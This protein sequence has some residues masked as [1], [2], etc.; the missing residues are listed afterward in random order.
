MNALGH[1]R[2]QGVVAAIEYLI[3]LAALHPAKHVLAIDPLQHS[4][5]CGE[6]FVPLS[7]ELMAEVQI[8]RPRLLDAKLTQQ[9][10]L[11]VIHAQIPQLDAAGDFAAA[12][13]DLL[14]G[15]WAHQRD[16]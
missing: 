7:L 9:K 2:V 12:I 11:G 5:L 1:S 8:A 16:D 15:D 10:V 13:V 3:T 14:Q 4:V 6:L